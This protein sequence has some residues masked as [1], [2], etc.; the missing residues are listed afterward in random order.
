MRSTQK[1]MMNSID[2]EDLSPIQ[3][4][5]SSLLSYIGMHYPKYQAESMHKLIATTLEDVE[6]GK[7]KRLLIN[8][9]PQHGK[10]SWEEEPV[11]MDDGSYKN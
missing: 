5:S 7:I 1:K 9:P 8:T 10:P 2:R 4:A 6:A 11:L 3:I